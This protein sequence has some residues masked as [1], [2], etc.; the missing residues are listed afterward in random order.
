[1][2]ASKRVLSIL[3]AL[4]AAALSVN[5][6]LAQH[7]PGIA[8]RRIRSSHFSVI[9][10]VGIEGDAAAVTELLERLHPLLNRTVGAAEHVTPLLL[11][12]RYAESNGFAGLMP[13]RM[14][15]YNA[16]PQDGTAGSGDWYTLLAIH[17]YRHMLQFLSMKVHLGRALYL[18]LGEQGLAMAAFGTV[19]AWYFEGDAVLSE[20]VFTA[21]GRGRMPEFDA[22]LR[23]QL[24][25]GRRF[26]YYQSLYGSYREYNPLESPYLMGY[27]LTTKLRRVHGGD[28][29]ARINRRAMWAP[30]LPYRHTHCVDALTGKHSSDWYDLVLDE[31]AVL[32]ARQVSGLRLTGAVPIEGS[33]RRDWIDSIGPQGGREGSVI[34]YRRGAE[35][36]PRIVSIDAVTGEETLIAKTGRLSAPPSTAEGKTV[37]SE[38]VPHQRWT[39]VSYSDIYIADLEDGGVRRIT[40]G[41]RYYAPSLSPDMRLVAAAEY[42]EW[43]RAALVIL[44]AVNGETL[45]RVGSKDGSIRTP[46]WSRRGD[47]IVF[48][49]VK[50]DR[51]GGI[52]IF[53]CNASGG[54]MKTHIPY[55]IEH[56]RNPFM[57]D[58]H[59]FYSSPCTGIDTICALDLSDSTRYLV[60]S[61]MFGAY[62]PS[63][64]PDGR[65]LFYSD[66][67]DQGLMAMKA[68]LDPG[69]WR[70]I[71]EMP[72]RVVQYFE[73]ILEQEYRV[74][75]DDI[76]HSAKNSERYC[77][78]L[79]LLEVHSWSPGFD[80]IARD[81]SVMIQSND[82]LETTAITAGYIYNWNERTHAGIA[83]VA[84]AGLYPV[85]ELEGLYGGRASTRKNSYGGTESY[86]WREGEA[87][88]K[89]SIPLDFSRR[90]WIRRLTLSSKI[91]YDFVRGMDYHDADENG[92][93]EFIPMHY[94]IVFQNTY[95]W[96][97]DINPVWG[98]RCTVGYMHTPFKGDYRGRLLYAE[99]TLYFP[100]IVSH[101]SLFFQCSFEWQGVTSYHF[102]SQVLYPRGYS[103][104]FHE[105][106]LC[107]RVNYTMPLLYPD[108]NL[109]IYYIKR[110]YMNCYGDYGASVRGERVFARSAGGELVFE[111]MPLGYDVALSVGLRYAYRF[112][113]TGNPH[114]FAFIFSV[115][116]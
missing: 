98:Q 89:A 39:R 8:W 23:A 101:H 72:S 94:R 4:T 48:C 62:Y 115:G 55:G 25:T 86:Q 76:P 34:L 69:T 49:K 21:S 92:N 90:N 70:P 59:V 75:L 27:F 58:R 104:E 1:M 61:R 10:P 83:S 42:D 102:P 74:S 78:G 44:D 106:F 33:D 29:L 31:L 65:W 20:T 64:S 51:E 12:T 80:P 2:A 77:P 114:Y 60:T 56:L 54:D 66:M 28:V 41:G 38:I 96:A 84:Y 88:L 67:T 17:E 85:I 112:D 109:Y 37:W 11:F 26:N 45:A 57:D 9:H 15:F 103:Y 19:P 22:A 52:G 50:G 5:E 81:I 73:Q 113:S 107:G 99:T 97:R 24:L 3:I 13:R 36:S 18:L 116:L 71:R 110:I 53:S 108:L 14:V 46:R 111:G 43:N 63:V 47:R 32:W 91:S 87:G 93:G 68:K 30:L 40:R 16:P 95:G 35:E 105:M 100:G 82:L 6:N 79:H 7:G